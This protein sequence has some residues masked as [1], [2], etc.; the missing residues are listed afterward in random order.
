MLITLKRIKQLILIFEDGL[1]V[2]LLSATILL[3]AS[4]IVLRNL[5]DSGLI[6]ADPTLRIMVLW[7]ALLGAIAATR[8]NRHIRIDIL[9]HRLSKR[10][11][12]I[13]SGVN[14][15][16]S[17]I[18]CAI[19]T[20]H[21]VRFVHAEWQDG[22]RLFAELPAW[23]GEIIIPIGFGVMTLRFLFN[24]SLQLLQRDGE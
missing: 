20:W 9:T 6:W 2:L 7:L 22:A 10:S 23:L 4:Q 21:A 8:E 18:V 14:D 17:A 5:F 19:I 13:L 3:A 12:S 15:L 16:F 11:Q 1:M 24:L